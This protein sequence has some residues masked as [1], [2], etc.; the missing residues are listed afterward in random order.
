MAKSN[1]AAYMKI[2]EANK[3]DPN[4]TLAALCRHHGVSYQGYNAWRKKNNTVVDKIFETPAYAPANVTVVKIPITQVVDALRKHKKEIT[5]P[6]DTIIKNAP[7]AQLQMI[8][9]EVGRLHREDM[10]KRAK[11]NTSHLP[12]I[13]VH[14]SVADDGDGEGS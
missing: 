7:S 8:D 5:I 2:K 3:K 6:I 12:P 14:E 10:A 9:Q 11:T 1:S 4:Q 13:I